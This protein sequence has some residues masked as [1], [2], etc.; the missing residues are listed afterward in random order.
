MFRKHAF[1]AK[2]VS[3]VYQLKNDVLALLADGRHVVHLDNELAAMKVYSC[4]FARTS[5]FGCPGSNE[6]SFHNQPTL[7][8]AIDQRN[9]QHSFFLLLADKARR[10]PNPQNRKSLNCQETASRSRN[11]EVEEVERVETVERI[12]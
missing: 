1:A 6:L 8:G 7:L 3:F 9:L 11:G 12:G 10:T 2:F 4:L 5:Q